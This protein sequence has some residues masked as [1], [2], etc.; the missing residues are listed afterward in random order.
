MLRLLKRLIG[1][2]PVPPDPPVVVQSRSAEAAD[3]EAAAVQLGTSTEPWAGD[4][5]LK[6]LLDSH[7]PVRTAAREA[8]RVRGAT[9]IPE[10]L[11]GLNHADQE[12]AQVSAELLGD[13]KAVEVVEPLVLALKFTSR[14]VQ[15]AAKRSLTKLGA[16]AVPALTA[17][18]DEP[19]PWIRQQVTEILANQEA[20]VPSSEPP[21]PPP[22]SDAAGIPPSP[23]EGEG[24]EALRTG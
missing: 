24:G 3:R 14:P 11:R 6:L 1:G 18:R 16:L 19:Q 22:Q 8:L 10:L 4:V 21:V 13:V 7:T 12:V 5:L 2:K 20:T 15:L 9:A 23:L 17:A